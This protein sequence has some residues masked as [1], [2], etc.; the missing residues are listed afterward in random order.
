[1][2]PIKLYTNCKSLYDAVHSSRSIDDG[3]Y[4]I[5]ISSLHETLLPN[6]VKKYLG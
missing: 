4:L 6:E 5:D 3:N 2:I 1:M